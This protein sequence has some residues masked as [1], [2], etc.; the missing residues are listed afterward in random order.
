MSKHH[1]PNHAPEILI[2][3]ETIGLYD[4]EGMDILQY[5]SPLNMY[6]REVLLDDVR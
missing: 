6:L 2:V 3:K 5:M 1:G 4:R